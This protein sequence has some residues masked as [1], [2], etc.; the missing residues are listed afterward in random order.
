MP[1]AHTP[2]IFGARRFGSSMS[3]NRWWVLSSRKWSLRQFGAVSVH[4]KLTFQSRLSWRLP[5][6]RW[7]WHLLLFGLQ[8]GFEILK[9][10]GLVFGFTDSSFIFDHCRSQ[11]NIPM[12]RPL[13]DVNFVDELS[14]RLVAAVFKGIL[15]VHAPHLPDIMPLIFA[16]P[17]RNKQS[18]FLFTKTHSNLWIFYRR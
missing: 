18:L 2:T 10:H 14:G 1:W 3:R 12:F 13:L 15:E 6:K 7:R 11:D 5:F 16:A 17:K 4:E 8:H 9:L